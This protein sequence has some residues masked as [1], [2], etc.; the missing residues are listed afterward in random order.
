MA[1]PANLLTSSRLEGIENTAPPTALASTMLLHV[2]NEQWTQHLPSSLP[3]RSQ[4][5]GSERIGITTKRRLSKELGSYLGTLM[6][7]LPWP[8]TVKWLLRTLVP[9]SFT[10]RRTASTSVSRGG[11]CRNEIGVTWE[12]NCSP[13]IRTSRLKLRV[14]APLPQSG[15]ILPKLSCPP[16]VFTCPQ[17]VVA[18]VPSS[19]FPLASLQRANCLFQVSS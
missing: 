9:L 17:R 4:E 6:T 18:A 1:E 15:S 10:P 19:A 16:S 13:P 14:T 3:H 2:L 5:A 12:L 7:I 8:S 11:P